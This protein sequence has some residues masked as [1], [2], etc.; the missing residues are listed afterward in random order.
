MVFSIQHRSDVWVLLALHHCRQVDCDWRERE[1]ESLLSACNAHPN[2]Y[3][4]SDWTLNGNSA[5]WSLAVLLQSD[6][7]VKLFEEI[8][9]FNL[10]QQFSDL[11]CSLD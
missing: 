4:S 3:K 9:F 5:D 11:L 10:E 7:I 8:V 1:R 6:W 2:C